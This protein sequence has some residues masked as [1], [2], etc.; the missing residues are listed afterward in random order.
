MSKGNLEKSMEN[1]LSDTNYLI[2]VMQRLQVY[3]GRPQRG[4]V[5]WKLKK[6]SSPCKYCQIIV[7]YT[8]VKYTNC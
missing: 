4:Y 3:P 8:D 7:K 1:K 5:A 6:F 2:V